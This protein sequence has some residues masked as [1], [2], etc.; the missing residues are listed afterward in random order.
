MK[1]N[2]ADNHIPLIYETLHNTGIIKA[3]TLRYAINP[4]CL[5]ISKGNNFNAESKIVIN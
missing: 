4:E 5:K 1:Y 2:K 3:P